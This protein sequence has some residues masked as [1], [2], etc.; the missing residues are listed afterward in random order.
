[1]SSL[2]SIG[3]G[4][5]ALGASEI[6]PFA[7]EEAKAIFDEAL[8]LGISRFDTAP[9]YGGGQSEDRLGMLLSG[10]PR[11][12]YVLS[13]KVGRYRPYGEVLADQRNNPTDVY[14]YSADTTFQSIES[15]LKRLGTDRLDIVYVHDCDN[16]VED[17]VKHT[18]P[19]LVQLRDQG[20]IGQIGIGSNNAPTHEAILDR[21]E[22][23]VLMVANSYSLLTQDADKRLF[24][25]C[26]GRTIGVELAAPFNSGILA[27][28]SRDAA[29]MYRYAAPSPEVMSRTRKIE[30]VCEAHGVSL[31]QAALQYCA[32][33]PTVDRLILGLV[34]PEALRSNLN[35]LQA[36]VPQ[37]FWDE[38]DS[39][40]IPSPTP[41]STQSTHGFN[42][43]KTQENC[44]KSKEHPIQGE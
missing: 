19:A 26:Q 15:S 43:E 20:V 40:G 37:G 16:F 11:D 34:A 13:T 42:K 44:V 3:L 1:M 6:P 35:D 10:I 33:H 24:L 36:A 2:A 7:D 27:V 30:A 22:V 39:I 29:A 18:L 38:L 32:R 8:A 31:K 25:L 41:H 4:F 17:A 28:G 14:D 9:L 5:S 23:D 12:S 21:A